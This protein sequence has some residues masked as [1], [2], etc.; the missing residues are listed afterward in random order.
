MELSVT[1]QI[2][3]RA[4]ILET[5]HVD[6]DAHVGLRVTAPQQKQLRCPSTSECG[7][8]AWYSQGRKYRVA[9]EMSQLEP[10]AMPWENHAPEHGAKKPDTA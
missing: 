6:K 5:V 4:L 3:S 8:K 9:M 1:Q 10:Q 2:H 7:N